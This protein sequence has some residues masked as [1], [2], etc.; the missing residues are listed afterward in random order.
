[1]LKEEHLAYAFDD[2]KRGRLD[3]DKIPMIRVHTVPHRPWNVRGPRYPDP[4]D[5]RKV[6]AY[7]N[8][9][10]GTK[11]ADYSYEPYASPWFCFIKPNGTLRFAAKVEHLQKLVRKG[12]ESEWG[13]EQ[14][15][16]VE[17]IKTKFREG[18]LILGV[19]FFDDDKDCPFV[20]E[21]DAGPTALG[22]V[23]IQKDVEGQEKPL[24]YESRT[25]NGAERN[26]SQFK[27]ETL[28][29]LHC[30]RVFRNYVFGRRFILRVDPTTLAQSLRNYSP[31][32]P[33]IARWLT[34]IWMF[35]FEIERISGSQNRADGLSRVEWDPEL[36]QAE[37][38]VP[39]DAFL[40][41]EESQLSMN[42]FTYLTDATTRHG[43]SIWNAPT[44]YEVRSKLMMEEPFIEEDPWGEQTSE[45]MMRLALTNA[46][47]LV[48]DPLTI[49]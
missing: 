19:P 4:E 31:S 18:G 24:R 48:L 28:A 47:N 35:D 42:S 15:A 26:Y 49:E 23:L 12:Q 43:R 41:E 2:D 14:Q 7:L 29:V 27:K 38:L 34:Y 25:L 1:M 9:K 20:I 16:T 36:D 30:L 17:D 22:G 39:V 33:T 8:G 45:E 44:F 32:D 37:G 5:H 6:V 40:K 21:T 13:P 10:I 3:V 46:I 11:V